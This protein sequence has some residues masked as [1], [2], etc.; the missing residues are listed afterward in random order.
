MFSYCSSTYKANI[1][2]ISIYLNAYKTTEVIYG[3]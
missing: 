3:T 2:V 1:K